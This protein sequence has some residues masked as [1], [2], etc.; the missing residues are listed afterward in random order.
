MFH[1]FVK[2][3]RGHAVFELPVPFRTDNIPQLDLIAMN[4]GFRLETEEL[5]DGWSQVK[6]I[7]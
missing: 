3:V 1:A 7:A 4:R 6:V 5:E 2:A